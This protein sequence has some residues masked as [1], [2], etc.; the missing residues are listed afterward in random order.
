MIS[1]LSENSLPP[2]N[3]HLALRKRIRKQRKAL[4][5]QERRVAEQDAARNLLKLG[6]VLHAQRIATYLSVDGE[7][8]LEMAIIDSRVRRA[9]IYAPVIEKNT[10]RFA[11]LRDDTDLRDNALGIPEPITNTYIAPRHLDIVL[12]PLVAFDN[13]GTRIGMGGGYYDRCFKFLASC[14]SWLKPKLIGIGYEFQ[15]VHDLERQ[16][17]DIPLWAAVT[18][19]GIYRF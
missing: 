17:W 1:P 16:S 11:P 5:E 9:L 19:R 10:L 2:S 6:A 15:R 7:L 12:T 14:S 4:P 13:D 3:R 8:D 18:D